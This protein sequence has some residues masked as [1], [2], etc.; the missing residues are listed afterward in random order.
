MYDA[1]PQQF[2]ERIEITIAMEERMLVADAVR[3]DHERSLRRPMSTSVRSSVVKPKRWRS[4][5][6]SSHSVSGLVTPLK[7]STR[8]LV[9]TMPPG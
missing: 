8:T 5:R 2:L 3:R 4:S 1:Q 6:K 9:S 7:K